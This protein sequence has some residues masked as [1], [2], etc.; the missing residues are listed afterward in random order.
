M[1]PG[2]DIALAMLRHWSPQ[3]GASIRSA[4]LADDAARTPLIPAANPRTG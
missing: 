1:C 3:A 2:C 4:A